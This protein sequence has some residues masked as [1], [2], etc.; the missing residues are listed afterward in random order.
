MFAEKEKKKNEAR[1]TFVF[2]RPLVRQGRRDGSA[3]KI[4]SCTYGRLEFG[5]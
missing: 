2:K 1:K 5:F 4:S 3:V